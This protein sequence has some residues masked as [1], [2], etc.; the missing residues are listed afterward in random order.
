MDRDALIAR[1]A[2]PRARAAPAAPVAAEKPL[3]MRAMMTRALADAMQADE[4]L[5]YL[6]E[7]NPTPNPNPS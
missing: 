4:R 7:A 6:G 3:E 2:P 1:C 5:L